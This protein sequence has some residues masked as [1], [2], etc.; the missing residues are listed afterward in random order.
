MMTD[1]VPDLFR[2]VTSP[3][4]LL[5]KVSDTPLP[6]F[7][8]I[9]VIGVRLAT[10]ILAPLRMSSA[11]RTSV[12]RLSEPSVSTKLALGLIEATKRPSVSLWLSCCHFDPVSFVSRRSVGDAMVGV[13]ETAVTAAEISTPLASK[14]CELFEKGCPVTNSYEPGVTLNVTSPEKFVFG[15][16]LN[17]SSAALIP[18]DGVS[19]M[20]TTTLPLTV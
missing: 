5:V 4:L 12:K 6:S 20:S 15:V 18:T 17:A 7:S 14:A 1:P 19:A 8:V 10:S 13:S 11:F 2:S 9:V 3:R 16:T